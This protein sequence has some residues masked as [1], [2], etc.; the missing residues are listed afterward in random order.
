V[1]LTADL[2]EARLSI[3]QAAEL[4]NMHP[5]HF[6]RLCRHGIFPR[7]NRTAKGRPYFD[8]ELLVAIGNVL[9]SGIGVN[10]EEIVFYRRKPKA[11]K[12]SSRRSAHKT[13]PDPYL[14]DLAKG[15]QQFGVAKRDLTPEKLTAALIGVFGEERPDLRVAVPA[16]AK[17]LLE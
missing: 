17:L 8:F 14:T 13:P 12:K 9:K 1:Q 7:P 16:L 6:R 5:S 3:V 4:A 10:Q 11:T 15:L 2:K